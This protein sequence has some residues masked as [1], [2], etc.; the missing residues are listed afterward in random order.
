MEPRETDTIV[1]VATPPGEG[2]LGVVRSSGPRAL[3]VADAMFRAAAPL[4][5][6]P[7]HTLHHGVVRDADETLDDAVAAVFRAPRAPTPAKTCVAELSCHGGSLLMTRVLELCLRRGARLAGPGEF[8][9]RA[10]ENGKMDL[11]QAEAVADLIAR[12]DAL[13]R[14]GLAQLRGGLSR[15]VATL[16]NAW[17]TCWPNWKPVWISW[18]TKFRLFRRINFKNT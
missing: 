7:S 14:A 17:W 5:D 12:S 13:R 2:G 6:V 18:T 16:R 4:V 10:Y 3:E 15:R 9:R 11:T 8:T 1:A